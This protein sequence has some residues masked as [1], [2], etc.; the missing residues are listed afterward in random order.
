MKLEE[1]V[2]SALRAHTDRLEWTTLDL[3]AIRASA[4]SQTRRRAAIVVGCV[5]AAIIAV[6]ASGATNLGQD[7]SDGIGPVDTP[8]PSSTRS[9]KN[10]MSMDMGAWMPYTSERYHSEAGPLVGHP[11]DW[12]VVPATR[13]WRF[14]TDA[15]DPLSPSHESFVDPTGEV[16]VSVWEVPL[17]TVAAYSECA[18]LKDTAYR[19]CVESVDYVLAWVGD[20][21]EASGIAAPCDG[22]EDRAVELCL[23]KR[24]CHPGV[25]VPFKTEVMAF[26][27]G[28]IYNQEAMTVV[29]VWRGE[30]D[31]SVA[32]YGGAQR[33]LEGFLSTMQVWPAS[34]PVSERKV[35]AEIE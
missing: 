32:R 14:G 26:F 17:D 18:G 22:I 9:P 28:G 12:T 34:T 24:D 5:M 23:E 13:E 10:A 15:A 8:S 21:C 31:P 19:L 11:P 16:R 33:L 35:A 2:V 6:V 27:G 1:R 25:L 20:Y 30:S 29:T 4:K 3:A 7:R